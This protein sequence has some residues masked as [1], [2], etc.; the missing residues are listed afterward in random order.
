MKLF[1]ASFLATIILSIMPETKLPVSFEPDIQDQ[2]PLLTFGILADVQYCDSDP[3]GS[4]FYRLST[5]KLREAIDTFKNNHID[6]IINLGDLIDKDFASYKPL[7]DII[8]SSGIRTFHIAGNH[9]YSVEPKQKK[10]IPVNNSSEGYYSFAE[11]DFR[12]IFLNGNEI[13]TYISNNKK[14]IKQAEE[15]L[16]EMKKSDAINAVEWNGGLSIQQ[17]KWLKIQLDEAIANNE[18]TF[19]LCHFPVA[20]DNVHNLLNYKEVLPL[21]ENYS[22]IVAWFNGHNHAGNFESINNV[23]FIT[24]QGMVETESSNSFAIVYVHKDKIVIRGY[25][26]EKN[27]TIE[28]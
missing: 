24:F 2:K 3:I 7:I 13:S 23:S 17:M 4:R 12:F 19:L 11:K 16:S 10:R 28:Y 9:D 14:T 25:G 15:Y 6:F 21:I 8:E 1:L 26:R 22:N 20:P 18:K 27:R 5:A